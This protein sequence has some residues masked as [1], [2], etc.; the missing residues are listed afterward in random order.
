MLFAGLP[1]HTYTHQ[2]KCFLHLGGSSISLWG[3]LHQVELCVFTYK[4]W[5]W[6]RIIT[7]DFAISPL[8]TWGGGKHSEVTHYKLTHQVSFDYI[9]THHTSNCSPWEIFCIWRCDSVKW[10]FL[11]IEEGGKT[12]FYHSRHSFFIFLWCK[13]FQETPNLLTL[14]YALPVDVLV[15]NAVCCTVS[16][17]L[18]HT[19]GWGRN[20]NLQF[21]AL[22]NIT[23]T[24]IVKPSIEAT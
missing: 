15:H 5:L 7:H 20:V 14:C 12:L 19:S 17:P 23:H 3:A 22:H 21:L 16:L 1:T 4:A 2:L 6:A 13:M 9:Q 11:L 10:L 18:K 24:V 8:K